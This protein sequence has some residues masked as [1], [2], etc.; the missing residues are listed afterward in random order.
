MKRSDLLNHSYTHSERT[1]EL[2]FR[3]PYCPQSFLTENDLQKHSDIHR[4]KIS[5]NY[6]NKL[7]SKS[8]LKRHKDNAHNEI[9]DVSCIKKERA[10]SSET[11]PKEAQ[12]E[13]KANPSISQTVETP[14]L[15]AADRIKVEPGTESSG[16][17]ADYSALDKSD[18]KNDLAES[19]IVLGPIKI[20]PDESRPPEEQTLATVRSKRCYKCK[21]CSK[22][23]TDIKELRLHEK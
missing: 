18:S 6:R 19:N 8:G 2:P 9:I 23:F 7:G 16:S 11:L 15:I 14:E 5:Q 12:V 17:T 10:E 22:A 3:C 4:A 1:D 13:A 20:E 21:V